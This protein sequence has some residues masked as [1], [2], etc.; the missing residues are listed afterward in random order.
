VAE[1]DEGDEVVPEG[2]SPE[3]EQQRRGSATTAKSGG[4][5]WRWILV[6]AQE[7]E[8]RADMW[9]PHVSDRGERT[10]C[11]PKAQ[12]DVGNIFRQ[13]AKGARACQAS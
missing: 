4:G 1:G 10:R 2:C 3:D 8:Q 13:G 11:D 12:T 6:A 5:S 9:G 7:E